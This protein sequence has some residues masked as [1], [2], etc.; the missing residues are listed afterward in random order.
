MNDI[1]LLTLFQWAGECESI[2]ELGCWRGR[3]THALLSGCKGKVYAVDHWLGSVN[4]RSTDHRDARTQDI[5]AQFMQNVGHFPNLEVCRLDHDV[6]W[7]MLPDVDMV[8]IDG[9]HSYDAVLRDASRWMGKAKRRLCGHDVT[10]VVVRDGLFMANIPFRVARS[11]G[12]IW[13]AV[14]EWPWGGMGEVGR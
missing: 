4:E 1:D 9:E 12:I 5:Y 13:E 8:F 2:V 11:G 7:A 6:A 10:M 3:S 14:G